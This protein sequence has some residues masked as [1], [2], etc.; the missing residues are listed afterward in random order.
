MGVVDTTASANESTL[1]TQ[2]KTEKSSMTTRHLSAEMMAKV[3]SEN[4][5]VKFGR[6]A[7]RNTECAVHCYTEPSTLALALAQTLAPA[8]TLAL[9]LPGPWP[10]TT[11]YA[12]FTVKETMLNLPGCASGRHGCV[13]VRVK[14]EQGMSAAKAKMK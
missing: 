5:V 7:G 2:L 13:A 14:A 8:P 11:R 4:A 6:S 9:S 10:N 1:Q 3:S 12:L